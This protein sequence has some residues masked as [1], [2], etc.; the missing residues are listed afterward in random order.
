[1]TKDDHAAIVVFTSETRQNILEKGGSGDWV[2][3]PKNAGRRNIW[4]AAAGRIGK[5]AQRELL[6]GRPF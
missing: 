1:M 5:I 4:S 3:S 6:K 2:L